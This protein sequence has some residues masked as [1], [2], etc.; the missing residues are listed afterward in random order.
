MSQIRYY[1][2]EIVNDKM[3]YGFGQIRCYAQW[4]INTTFSANEIYD[5]IFIGD[6]ASASNREA[7]K[8]QGITHIMSIMN[9]AYEIFPNDFTYK[10]LH[11]NDDPWVDISLTFE[12]SN[13][14]IDKA[15]SNPTDK[16]M[17]HC[18]R[19][20]S[21]SVTLLLAYKLKK[22]NE[23]KQIPVDQIEQTILSVLAEVKI[24]RKIADPNEGFLIALKKYISQMT[25]KKE[26]DPDMRDSTE[27][28]NIKIE[29]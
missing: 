12:E 26:N 10:I 5:R 28:H 16:I 13:D 6:L 11:L 29:N 24:H 18:Q 7:M 21:R 17:I 25:D 15:L 27:D 8:E 2:P 22:I 19:G 1:L 20:I 3:M 23:K 4:Y 14:F 9:G